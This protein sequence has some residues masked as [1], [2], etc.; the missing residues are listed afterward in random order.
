MPMYRIIRLLN[1]PT[2]RRIVVWVAPLVLGWIMK[3]LDTPAQK[4]S[5]STTKKKK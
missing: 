4:S 5:S 2:V 1:N 3:K